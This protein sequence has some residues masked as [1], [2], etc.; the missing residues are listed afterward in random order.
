MTQCPE[1]QYRGCAF[2]ENV[3]FQHLSLILEL[4]HRSNASA[5]LEGT[6]ILC[7]HEPSHVCKRMTGLKIKEGRGHAMNAI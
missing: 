6:H 5:F 4:T 1:F 7:T 2:Q 3:T